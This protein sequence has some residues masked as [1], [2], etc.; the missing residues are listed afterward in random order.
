MVVCN[1]NCVTLRIKRGRSSLNREI[2][3]Y[4]TSKAFLECA[5]V[6]LV[7]KLDEKYTASVSKGEL[8]V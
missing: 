3:D 1:H 7:Y 5:V 2:F 6:E 4:S 8:T